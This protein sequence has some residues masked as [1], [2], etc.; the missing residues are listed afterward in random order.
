MR[1]VRA[2][3]IPI[4]RSIVKNQLVAKM[5]VHSNNPGSLAADGAKAAEQVLLGAVYSSDPNS[6]NY[7]FSKYT[8]SASLSMH[9]T[10]PEAFDF[11]VEGA[12]YRLTF[13]R[14]E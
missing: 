9:I 4:R 8:P 10:N 6:E 7:S 12:Q 11:F 1:G 14:V 3:A 2:E 5:Q 13:E